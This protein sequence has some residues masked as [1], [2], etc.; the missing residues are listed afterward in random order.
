MI[1]GFIIVWAIL[2]LIWQN[3]KEKNKTPKNPYIAKHSEKIN[4]DKNYREYLRWCEKNG[5]I[6]M[7]KEVFI[8]EIE[9]KEKYLQDLFK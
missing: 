9:N 1:I 2:A 7:R 5:E 6:P 8:R 3:N 4:N